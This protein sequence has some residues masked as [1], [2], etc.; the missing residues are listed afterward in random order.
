MS[1]SDLSSYALWPLIFLRLCLRELWAVFSRMWVVGLKSSTF[2]FVGMGVSGSSDVFTSEHLTSPSAI[3][4][5]FYY[6][7]MK[8]SSWKCRALTGHL[9]SAK[10]M[11]RTLRAQDRTHIGSLQGKD[12]TTKRLPTESSLHWLVYV[13]LTQ[14]ES[15]ERREP[16]L[17]K[18]FPKM[19]LQASW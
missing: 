19:G 6:S 16:Q 13:N 15:P 5:A 1:L 14:Q 8:A 11:R 4:L 2:Y 12:L 17:R 10:L 18:S 7:K 3:E 9:F